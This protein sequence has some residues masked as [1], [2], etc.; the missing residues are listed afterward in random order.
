MKMSTGV[1]LHK[2]QFTVDFL[3]EDRANDK[4]ATYLTNDKGYDSFLEK[5]RKFRKLGY[6][7]SVA[8][9][10]T[11]NA[12][13]FR[14]KLLT[15]N[16]PVKVVNTS[17]FKV[18]NQSVKKTDK[19]DARTLAEFL[20]KDMLPESVLC[21]QDSENIRRII[22]TR[23]ILVKSLV[24]LKN[25]IH[26]LLLSYGVETKIGQLQSKRERQRILKGLEDHRIIGNAAK[27]VVP[28]FETIDQVSAEVKKLELVLSDLVETDETVNLLQTIPGVGL[29][30]ASTIRA[31]TDDISRFDSEKKYAAY[32]GLV[33][34][35]Q[36]SNMSVH[37]GKIT[38]RGPTELRTALVQVVLGM[39]RCRSKTE[40]YRIM[41][42][43]RSMKT[44]KGSGRSIIAV[45]RKMSNIIF[46]M[47]KNNKP[48]NPSEMVMRKKYREMQAA[49][50]E[51]A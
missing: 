2:T 41:Q 34:W 16:I 45:A 14:N 30:I 35:V 28:L 42:K 13:Y 31:Y 51:V 7:V 9:E 5:V 50:W 37:H 38:K 15:A 47:L 20:E 32:A 12:R 33:P 36:N 8:V 40:N 24:S 23:S 3:S 39:V 44:N 6:E 26:G 27:T 43:Y 48:F 19:H 46:H 25:Q 49:A 10:A 22:K 17:K 1:D 18:I 21:S 29:I 4:A 11:G